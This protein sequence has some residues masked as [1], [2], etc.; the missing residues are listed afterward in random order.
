MKCPS[1]S[2]EFPLTWERYLRAP[3]GK[4]TCPSC[5]KKAK[6]L[7]TRKYILCSLVPLGA[8]SFGLTLFFFYL[9]G[10][11]S[12]TG[13]LIAGGLACIVAFVVWLPVDRYCDE[14]MRSLRQIDSNDTA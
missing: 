10:G 11:Q 8:F 5:K 9:F 2:F 3:F 14:N 4:H 1:C 13:L 12:Y 6:L 7:Y